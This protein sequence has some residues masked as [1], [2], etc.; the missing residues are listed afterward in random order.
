MKVQKRNMGGFLPP[1]RHK[2]VI[3]TFL[4]VN[5]THDPISMRSRVQ[6]RTGDYPRAKPDPSLISKEVFKCHTVLQKN[7]DK[8]GVIGF[9]LWNLAG[10]GVINCLGICTVT[11]E[12]PT[13]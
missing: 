13:G 4:S 11:G 2:S 5:E 3:R 7:C 10:T 9:R 8:R 12:K 1:D 6:R